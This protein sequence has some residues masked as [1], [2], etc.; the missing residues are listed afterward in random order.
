MESFTL[1]DCCYDYYHEFDK[2]QKITFCDHCQ[3]IN[4]SNDDAYKIEDNII[5]GHCLYDYME[6]Y[7][8]CY[9]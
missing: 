4:M 2:E 1:P 6:K 9:R 7:K 8:L 5:H 3:H